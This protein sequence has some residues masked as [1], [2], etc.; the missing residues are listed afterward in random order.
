MRQCAGE[1]LALVVV[2]L[3]AE[4][5]FHPHGEFGKGERFQVGAGRAERGVVVDTVDAVVHVRQR[6]EHEL[7]DL[8]DHC[9]G[10]LPEGFADSGQAVSVS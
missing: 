5:V 9:R 2:E 1:R 7:A 3:H 4:T 6:I 8:I 10:F